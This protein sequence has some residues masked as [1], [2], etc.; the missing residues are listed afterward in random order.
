MTMDIKKLK[1]SSNLPFMAWECLTIQ[2][3][4]RQVDLVIR[5]QENMDKLLK[6][7]IF[8]LDTANG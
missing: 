1:D 2:L 7:L 6:F 3:K 5:N 4:D 8:H